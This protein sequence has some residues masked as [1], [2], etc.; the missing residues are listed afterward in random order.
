VAA[1]I[2]QHELV[3]MSTGI[4]CSLS[5][6][7]STTQARLREQLQGLQDSMQLQQE[8]A[9]QALEDANARSQ[10]GWPHCT[11]SSCLAAR[12]PGSTMA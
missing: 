2:Q 7:T 1:I 6:S 9:E 10:V 8:H 5:S 3:T 11:R 12:R 4:F